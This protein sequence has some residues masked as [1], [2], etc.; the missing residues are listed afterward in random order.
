[1]KR[2]MSVGTWYVHKPSYVER[3]MW[4]GIFRYEP[5]YELSDE[6][7]QFFCL[8]WANMTLTFD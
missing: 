1:M 7:S 2:F 4:L 8:L 6:A 3:F 5:S